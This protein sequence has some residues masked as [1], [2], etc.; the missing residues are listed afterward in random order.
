[1]TKLIALLVA[2]FIDP[3]SA[4]AMAPPNQVFRCDINPEETV[5]V[6]L[7]QG[8]LSYW[9]QNAADPTRNVTMP[10]DGT[11][12]SISLYHNPERVVDGMPVET[13]RVSFHAEQMTTV[14]SMDMSPEDEA[15]SIPTVQF[16]NKGQLIHTFGCLYDSD[17][18]FLM[19]TA[20]ANDQVAKGYSV[21]KSDP[22]APK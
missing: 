19:R 3:I 22:I 10:V 8:L 13:I 14:I 20:L 4:Y 12:K 18:M 6:T 15:F 7:D 1:M 11:N 5:Y 2:L 16:M 17:E 9:Y 21:D